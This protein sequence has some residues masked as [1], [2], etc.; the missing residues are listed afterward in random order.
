MLEVTENAIRNIKAYLSHQQFDD[1]VRITLVAD[2]CAAPSL[3][4]SVDE[5]K[6]TDHTFDRD[7][8]SFVLDK[9]LSE[10]CGIIKVDYIDK[11]DDRC[12]C[13]SGDFSVTSEKP[14][15]R[16]GYSCSY[17]YSTRR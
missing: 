15:S 3:W 9:E 13:P 7:G 16:N 11:I 10:C 1:A 6:E 14:L 5:A 8:I 17:L 4:L 12:G 2:S